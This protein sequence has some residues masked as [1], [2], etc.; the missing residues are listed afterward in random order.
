MGIAESRC[1]TKTFVGDPS[2]SART[3]R[4]QPVMFTNRSIRASEVQGLFPSARQH[5]GT[6]S[7]H[8]KTT[9]ELRIGATEYCRG[10]VGQKSTF[11]RFSA[12]FDFRLLQHLPIAEVTRLQPSTGAVQWTEHLRHAPRGPDQATAALLRHATNSRRRIA[13]TLGPTWRA[14]RRAQK[15]RQPMLTGWRSS[16]RPRQL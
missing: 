16:I 14:C 7:F 2:R 8:T 6:T 3:L 4:N 11:A 12:S 9:T 10:G 1:L 5:E 15:S 13:P